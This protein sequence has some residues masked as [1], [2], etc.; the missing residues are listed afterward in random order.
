VSGDSRGDAVTPAEER[1][2]RHLD[3]L[4]RHPPEPA[5]ELAPIVVRRARWQRSARPYLVAVGALAMG[6][7]EGAMVA[8]GARR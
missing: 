2:L 4:G 5:T 3:D 8:L 1:L 6:V 7:A